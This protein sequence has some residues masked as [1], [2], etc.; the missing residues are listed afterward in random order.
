MSVGSIDLSFLVKFSTAAIRPLGTGTFITFTM[1]STLNA[2]PSNDFGDEISLEDVIGSDDLMTSV[3]TVDTTSNVDDEEE[4]ISGTNV[5]VVS[6][7][8]DVLR[9]TRTSP[10]GIVLD[11][12]ESILIGKSIDA[13]GLVTGTVTESVTDLLVIAIGTGGGKLSGKKIGGGGAKGS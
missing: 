11:V 8:E 7:G 10:V 1:G 6:D 2:V 4:G 3:N 9:T 13:I 5:P 12:G